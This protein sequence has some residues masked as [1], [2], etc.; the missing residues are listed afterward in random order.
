[1]I[2]FLKLGT[3]ALL[4][5]LTFGCFW[6]QERKVWTPELERRE[7]ELMIKRDMVN[8]VEREA[9]DREL[10]DI[11][12]EWYI[13]WEEEPPKPP[14]PAKSELERVKAFNDSLEQQLRPQLGQRQ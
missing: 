13:D 6:G 14:R 4:L 1:M 3:V 7:R 8:A 10:T 2:T 11:Q 5:C 12:H 9:I